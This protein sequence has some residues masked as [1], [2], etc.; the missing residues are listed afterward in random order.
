MLARAGAIAG[1]LKW[2][3]N[4]SRAEQGEVR[5]PNRNSAPS[6]LRITDM[7]AV[8]VA[9]NYDYPIIRIDTNQGVYGLGEARDAGREGTALVLK[10]HLVGRNPLGIEP[11]LDSIRNFANHQRMGGGYA[12]VDMA[13]HDIAGKVYGVPAWRL[14]GS[15]YRDRIRIYCDTDQSHDPRIFGQ[16]LKK[17]QEIGFTF[18]KMDL[19]TSLVADRPGAVDT[20]GIA[21]PKGLDYLGEYVQTVRDAIGWDVPLATDHFG[22]LTLKDSIR[23]ARSLEKYDL[24]WAEDMIQIGHLGPGGDAPKNWRAYRELKES[25]TTPINT[26]ESLF[27]LEEGFRDLIENEAVDIIHPD[28][29][30]SGGIRET[31]RIGDYA[32]M[33]GIQT[34]IHFAGSPVGCMASVH[35]AATLKDMLAMENHAV[36]IPWWGDLVTGPGKPIVDRGFINVPETPGL[37]VELNEAVVK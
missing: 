11:I 4:G 21:T 25:T 9:S 22:P 31:K 14:V 36:D 26:G 15:K 2:T 23:Y 7:R 16:R 1:L 13:L 10:P 30:T 32:C 29:L 18:F 35:M 5:P 20:R 6:A 17:R 3:E 28:P 12:A 33:H 19:G 8:L 34:A 27:G 24:A 37:G